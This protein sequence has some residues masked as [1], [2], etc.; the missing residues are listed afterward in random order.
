MTISDLLSSIS[1]LLVFLTILITYISTELREILEES[2]PE[3]VE[4]KKRLKFLRR[5]RFVLFVKSI[6]IT[7]AFILVSYVLLPESTRILKTSHLSLWNFNSLN[8]LFIIIELGI[9]GFT[10]YSFIQT[11]RLIKK[12][13]ND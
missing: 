11:I 8:T 1:I 3:P 5:L 6:P 4:V 9:I 12:L 10:V 13:T 2:K 7:L